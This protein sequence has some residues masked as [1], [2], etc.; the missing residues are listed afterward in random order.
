VKST[1]RPYSE[2]S[3]GAFKVS[4]LKSLSAYVLFVS[5]LTHG[6]CKGNV[7]CQNDNVNTSMAS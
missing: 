4:I 6:Y 5:N 2:F 3:D 1:K 7:N